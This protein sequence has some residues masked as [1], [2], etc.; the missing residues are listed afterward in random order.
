MIQEL[1]E[2]LGYCSL[3]YHYTRNVLRQPYSKEIARTTKFLGKINK[4]MGAKKT[5]YYHNKGVISLPSQFYRQT[6]LYSF[7]TKTYSNSS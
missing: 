4:K 5:K 1:H 6:M 2:F 3:N 7:S